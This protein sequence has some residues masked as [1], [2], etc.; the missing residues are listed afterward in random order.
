MDAIGTVVFAIFKIEDGTLTLAEVRHVRQA[1]G[2]F[3]Q[4]HEP[5]RCQ[6][7]SASRKTWPVPI[8]DP[9]TNL[10]T[11]PPAGRRCRPDIHGVGPVYRAGVGTAGSVTSWRLAVLLVSMSALTSAAEIAGITVVERTTLGGS[12]LVL[13]GAGL[14]KKLFFKV[15]VAGLYLTH[16]KRSPTE[17]FAL[18]GPKRA[19]ITLL[20]DLPAQELVLALTEGIRNNCS[21]EQQ[22][23]LKD[24]IDAL[25]ANLLSLRQ[26]KKGDVITVDWLPDQGTVV[27]LNGEIKGETIPGYDLYLALLRVWL[28]DHPTSVGLKRALLGQRD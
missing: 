21:P 26:G 23:A 1:A 19:S 10:H 14:R 25:A 12:E 7:G 15:Y 6:E 27:T 2:N 16:K 28:G 8:F 18:A 4:R 5:L 22:Q 9:A 3:C 13:N 17:V 24:R 20:R 11:K